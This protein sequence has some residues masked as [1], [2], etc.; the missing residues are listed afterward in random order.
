MGKK[1]KKAALDLPIEVEEVQNTDD[2]ADDDALIPYH[3]KQASFALLFLLF[4][5]VLMFT[6]P[7]GAFYGTKHFLQEY[8]HL[9][10]F[11]TTC[12]SVLAA[13]LTVNIVIGLYALF[14]FIEAR[15]E[16]A[17]VK[18]FAKSKTN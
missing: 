18:E 8:L 6:L 9:D 1:S 11:Q 13:V 4:F 17:T 15:K 5:S 16:E 10:T 14:G 3:T 12:W 7:F 2:P